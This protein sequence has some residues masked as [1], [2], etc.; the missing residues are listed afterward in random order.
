[1]QGQTSALLTV[2]QYQDG[3]NFNVR[4]KSNHPKRGASFVSSDS[5][6]GAPFLLLFL[7]T[8]ILGVYYPSIFG[9]LNSVDDRSRVMGLLNQHN[10]DFLRVFF[11]GHGH[12]YFRPLVSSSFYLDQL[13]FSC[14]P[15]IMHFENVV[16]HCLNVVL[17]F[18]AAKKIIEKNGEHKDTMLPLLAGLFFGLHPLCTEPV[19]WISGRYDLLATLFVLIS[20][21][22]LIGN[23]G[24]FKWWK[25]MF[26]ALFLLIGLLSKEVAAGLLVCLTVGLFWNGSPLFTAGWRNRLKRCIP[27]AG[28]LL[29]YTWM[30]TGLDFAQDSGLTS[31]VKGAHAAMGVPDLLKLRGVITALGFYMKKL[32]WPFPLNF[33]IVDINKIVYCS[34]GVLALGIL[35]W[36]FF[37]KRGKPRFFIL[38]SVAFVLPA[39]VVAVSRM[40]WTPLAERYLYTSLV[41]VSLFAISLLL[42]VSGK[43]ARVLV[44]TM[45]CLIVF[46]GWQTTK[47]N[48]VWQRN[49]TLFADVVK[50]SPSFAQG[51]NEY[52]I[53]LMEAGRTEDAK[54]EIALA[55]KLSGK[56]P[57]HAIA[58]VNVAFFGSRPGIE[59]SLRANLK[60][61]KL[62]R[63]L[64]ILFLRKLIKNI[65]YRILH[66]T[67]PAERLKLLRKEIEVQRQLYAETKNPFNLYREG[68]L[69]LALGEKD[70]ARTFFRKVCRQSNDY[71]TKPACK[72][73]QKLVEEQ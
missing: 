67:E 40:A 2:Q 22:I 59:K 24:D 71:Y 27:F 19:N 51:H 29:F 49:I 26:A 34:L 7:I 17:V 55:S 3:P 65:E 39:L 14:R 69:H 1:M 68:Q 30:R 32:V 31:A 63:K 52:G 21:N 46:F 61:R 70:L 6:I 10:F 48:F 5:I 33:A 44:L 18:F 4:M 41:G 50:Q 66:A 16:I 56:T 8:I 9:Q 25:E 45:V 11:G 62:P 57:F 73:Y 43:I 47:R 35:V 64:R 15:E 28:A 13:L 42:T 20:F 72:L 38:W 36:L 37:Q 58:S 60:I 12:Y 54:Q 23:T 53:A